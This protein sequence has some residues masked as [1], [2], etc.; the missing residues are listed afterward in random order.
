MRL[1]PHRGGGHAGPPHHEHPGNPADP[2][3]GRVRHRGLRGPVRQ[4]GHQPPA[5][6]ALVPQADGEV[7]DAARRRRGRALRAAVR[8]HADLRGRGHAVLR[9]GVAQAQVLHQVRRRGH[10]RPVLGVPGGHRPVRREEAGEMAER[11]EGPAGDGR[12]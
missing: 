6:D 2:V 9:A 12:R 4:R 5:A 3:A 1:L 7:R 8:G 11:A 10:V